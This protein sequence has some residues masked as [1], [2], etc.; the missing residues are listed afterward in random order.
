[1]FQHILLLILQLTTI[2]TFTASRA[3][4]RQYPFWFIDNSA[5]IQYWLY[6]CRQ[7]RPHHN[8]AGNGLYLDCIGWLLNSAIQLKKGNFSWKSPS[9]QLG[10][11]CPPPIAVVSMLLSCPATCPTHPCSPD[12]CHRHLLMGP[13]FFVSVL[14]GTS[15]KRPDCH[16]N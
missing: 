6:W 9:F 7:C 14:V 1:M 5:N 2:P 15:H 11:F 16:F 8:D 13:A 10:G 4:M 3:L 12:P